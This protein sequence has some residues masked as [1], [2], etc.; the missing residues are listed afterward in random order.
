MVALDAQWAAEGVLPLGACWGET[1]SGFSAALGASRGRERGVSEPLVTVKWMRPVPP[2]GFWIGNTRIRSSQV[3]ETVQ[4][5][6][7]VARVL[8]QAGFSQS[9]PWVEV[10]DGLEHLHA[11]M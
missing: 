8:F 5:P 6:A 2:E 9:P 10:T 11:I 4:V 1:S 3:G 7:E